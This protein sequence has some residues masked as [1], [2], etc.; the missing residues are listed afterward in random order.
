MLQHRQPVKH[1]I[2]RDM[3]AVAKAEH[4]NVVH[5]DRTARWWDVPRGTAKNAVLRPGERA[6]LNR[7]VVDEVN[8]LDV[9]ARI[10]EG[11][12]PTPKKTRRTLP[13][14]RRL[15]RLALR[16]RHCQQGLP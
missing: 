11:G 15:T 5:F 7:D 8:G 9:D 14:P 12:E 3:L 4:L 2:E 16:R 13:F 1:Q 10:R 6:L